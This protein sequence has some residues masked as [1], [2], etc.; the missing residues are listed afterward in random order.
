MTTSSSPPRTTLTSFLADF[1]NRGNET[2]FAVKRGVRVIRWSYRR[3]AEIAFQIAHELT[4]QGIE[5]GDRILMW[6][7]NSPE[8]VAAFFGCLLVGSVAVPLDSQST[9]EFVSRI[10]SQTGAKQGFC[11]SATQAQSPPE[12]SWLR[13]ETIQATV[14]KHPHTP[15]HPVEIKST[16]VAEII[17]TSGTTAE[18]RG[19]CLSH[20]NLL[21]NLQPLEQE[22]QK[23]LKWE[24]PFHPIRFLDLLPLS[25][26]F[27]QFM[28]VFVPQLLGGEV[29]FQTSVNPTEILET[30]R[31]ERISVCVI[32][33]RLLETLRQKV[34]RDWLVSHPGQSLQTVLAECPKE[35]F[36][37]RWWRFRKVHNQ[38]GW[39]FWAF[40]SGGATLDQNLEAFW[41]H[42]GFALIQ[43]YGM[44]ETASL[45]S[46]V[47]PFKLSQGSIGKA[48]PGRELKLDDGGEILVRGEN[49]AAGVWQGDKIQPLSDDGWLRTGDIGSR[50][51]E[52]NL[53][54]RG[55]KKEV[56]VTGAGMNIYPED[57]EAALLRQPEIWQAAVFGI[58]GQTGPEP[59]AVVIVRDE[60][61]AVDQL[62]ATVNAG[63]NPYQSIRRCLVWPGSDFPRTSTH[64]TRKRDVMAWATAQLGT[65]QS[66]TLCE[67]LTSDFLLTAIEKITHEKP[68]RFDPEANL[69]TDC[70][71]DSL[72]K[73]ELL[74]WLEDH[75]HIE[76][77]EAAFTAA[78]TVGQLQ[79]LI[80]QAIGA[81]SPGLRESK[82]SPV[83]P[84]PL[85]DA[86]Y[87]FPAWAM[88]APWTWLRQ[89]LFYSI[90]W[91]VCTVLCW[92]RVEGRDHLAHLTGP[93]VL[94]ANH[95]TIADHAL[96]L[97][98][99][100]AK[101]R[102][103]LAIAMEGERLRD[104]RFPPAGT[105]WVRRLW[106]PVQYLLIVLF[107]NVFP[108]PQKSG[109]RRS[110][111]YAGQ[112]VDQGFHILIF[113]EGRRS[114]EGHMHPFRSGIGVLAR[115]IQVPVVPVYLAG[116]YELQ[117]KGKQRWFNRFWAA[118]G[119]VQIRFG[120][121]VSFSKDAHPE[122]IARELEQAVRRLE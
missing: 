14:S 12:I 106:M 37:R 79:Y 10:I 29:H 28:G 35:H 69:T 100:P 114:E 120:P 4:A 103:R 81:T 30:I 108:L 48:L 47:H 50:D 61:T 46:V 93:V 31:R 54:F 49:I 9:P 111:R 44:T 76:L 57:L 89:L 42:L 56:I 82:A 116:L 25:H 60:Q 18:P 38:F 72:G 113:P 96:I 11:D 85:S 39:K 66:Q 62:L 21:V 63:L 6:A 98:A 2:A 77:D 107:F 34:E 118:P 74:S 105:G 24:R 40:I 36:A 73:V 94:V 109:F 26:V 59:V 41:R 80:E 15:W 58:D 112:A 23:Y 32:V 8:W 83:E 75:F 51:A 67:E 64:K 95:I 86:P 7:E 55:R 117:Q 99:L 19:I 27:G 20:R 122:H 70:R 13:L 78:T 91:P 101:V 68:L 16:D 53:F 119:S 97:A 92:T 52:G 104:F 1:L 88:R 87:P 5:P 22:I 102:S 43:G 71:L 33:P 90:V 121:S 115:E 17:F 65:G 110:F 3:T 84:Q 45:V